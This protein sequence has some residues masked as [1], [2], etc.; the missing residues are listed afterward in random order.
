MMSLSLPLL[1]V[2]TLQLLT[3]IHRFK[4]NRI[5]INRIKIN[6]EKW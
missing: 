3:K 6:I 5:K 2:Y 1:P 4:I